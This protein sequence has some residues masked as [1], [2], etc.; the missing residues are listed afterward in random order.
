MGGGDRVGL[1]GEVRG[2][3]GEHREWLARS[4]GNCSLGAW[5]RLLIGR[6]TVVHLC[7]GFTHGTGAFNFPLKVTGEDQ[8]GNR[9]SGNCLSWQYWTEN[10][11]LWLSGLSG[12]CFLP[13]CEKTL[14][15]YVAKVM[16]FS[17]LK[18]YFG[19][20]ALKAYWFP[21]K[22]NQTFHDRCAW[23]FLHCEKLWFVFLKWPTPRLYSE[24]F[25]PEVFEWSPSAIEPCDPWISF[26]YWL[27]MV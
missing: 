6:D 8:S 4:H 5:Y 20:S 27:L 14:K 18:N 25:S 24:I 10:M 11:A 26:Q 3:L 12:I 2:D 19:E 15:W 21:L 17:W 9:T 13:F 1:E 16:N 23:V 22:C 7:I